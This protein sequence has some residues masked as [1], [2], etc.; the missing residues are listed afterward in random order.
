[1]RR[2]TKQGVLVLIVGLAAILTPF[3]F[4]T[5]KAKAE[6]GGQQPAEPFRIA[7][8]FYYV[9]AN[10]V[11]S[12]LITGPEGHV[13][14]DGGY[15]GTAPMIVAS[16]ATLGFDIKDVKVLLNSSPHGD[17]AGGLA[18]LQQASGAEL[19]A[20]EA[21]AR[22]IASGGDDPDFALPLRTVVQIGIL[23]YP[24]ARVDHRFK[25]GDTIRVGPIA[26]T[27]HVT[28]GS[29][30]G[31]TS[32]SFPV[33]DGDRVLNVVSACGLMVV[34]GMRYS[35]QAADL[36]RSFQVLRSLPVDIW[37]TSRA[38]PWGRYRKFVASQ[39]A[40]NPVD[41]FIDPAGYRAFIDAAEEEFRRGVVH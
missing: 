25:D 5:W 37:V 29:S 6:R 22:V 12:F 4:R 27:A 32:W 34:L 20:S 8:N 23:G 10:D 28:G 40:K 9:G 17:H 36:E 39:T 18:A 26:L 24:P 19:W 38:R 11:T 21:S 13:L 33:R 1:L 3:L 35:E 31:C 41:P 16:I 30:R 2:V 7:G 15:P 14:L